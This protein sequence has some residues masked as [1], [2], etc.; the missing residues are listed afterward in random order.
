MLSA[1][2]A[3]PRSNATRVVFE[4]AIHSHIRL[5]QTQPH[6]AKS[7]T[8][9]PRASRRDRRSTPLQQRNS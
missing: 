4:I 2:H 1:R 7:T 9:P 6:A 8:H 3:E 5:Q